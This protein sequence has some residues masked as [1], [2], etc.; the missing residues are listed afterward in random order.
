MLNREN[1]MQVHLIQNNKVLHQWQ[2]LENTE[3]EDIIDIVETV[4]DLDDNV[5]KGYY[6]VSMV[7]D[8]EEVTGMILVK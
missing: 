8:G 3:L 7:Q 2:V 6:D 4:A 5:E 1:N